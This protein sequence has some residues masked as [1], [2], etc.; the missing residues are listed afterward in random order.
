M[1]LP[2]SNGA[3]VPREKLTAY[4]LSK[5]HPVGRAKASFFRLIGYDETNADDL[6]AELIRLAGAEEVVQSEASPFGTKYVVEGLIAGP[7]GSAGVRTVWII[8]T[9]TVIPR[10]VTAYP[11]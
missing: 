10:F 4:L 7:L 3:V 5:T 1:K 9:G 6:A 11:S 2:N 8:E